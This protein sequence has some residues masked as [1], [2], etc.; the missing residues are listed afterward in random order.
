MAPDVEGLIEPQPSLV[1]AR[2][3]AEFAPIIF[4]EYAAQ[5]F[6][7]IED[8]VIETTGKTRENDVVDNE[9]ALPN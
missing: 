4:K 2:G 8:Q 1:A 9:Q 5:I 7:L 3:S 6:G